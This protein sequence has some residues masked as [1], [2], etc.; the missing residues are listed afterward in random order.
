MMIAHLFRFLRTTI[1]IWQEARALRAQ[2][3]VRYG[4][5]GE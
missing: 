3:S 4:F 1:E 2:L 5:N